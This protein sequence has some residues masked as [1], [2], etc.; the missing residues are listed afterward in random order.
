MLNTSQNI[1]GIVLVVVA[2]LLFRYILQRFWPLEVRVKH[3]D[4]IGWQLGTL[5][6]TYAVI[7]GFMLYTVWTNYGMAEMNA[8]A[9][10]NA[11]V[12]I[13]RLA[14]G[15]PPQQRAD[16]VQAT[17][18]YADTVI[19]KDW[20]AMAR[21][22]PGPFESRAVSQQLWHI[23]M[24]IKTATPSEIM[25]ADH[26]LSELNSLAEHRRTRTLQSTSRLPVI[27]WLVLILGGAATIMSSCMFGA[28][29]STLHAIQVFCFSFL[30]AFV[31]MAIADID[32]PFQGQVHI[33]VDPFVRAQ[34]DMSQQ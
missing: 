27:L 2:A 16:L 30:I 11:L 12:N 33:E 4:I 28:T 14:E 25:A 18:A 34:Q 26:L 7:L 31:L 23:P 3:N 17:R 8:D 29:N 5:G 24:S 22:S 15:L 32:R 21:D 9:E 10:A 6:T 13:Y 19:N 1:L 20:P